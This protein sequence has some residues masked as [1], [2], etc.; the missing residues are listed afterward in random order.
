MKMKAIVAAVL[1]STATVAMANG[2][3][4]PTAPNVPQTP[5]GWLNRM[6]DFTKNQSAFKDPKVFVPWANAVTEPAFYT[7]MGNMMMDPNGWTHMFGTM[8][9]PNAYRNYA[10]WADPNVY[11]KWMAASMDPNF[12]TALLSQMTDPGKMMR[13]AMMPMDPK[14][15]SM[16]MQGMNPAMYMKWMMAPISPQTMQLGMAPLNPNL[17]MNWMGT[18]MNPS[19]YGSWGNWL[20]PMA[21]GG[22]AAPTFAWPVP[23]TQAA[24][25]PAGTVNFFD[26]NAWAKMWTFPTAQPAPAA[27]PAEPAA[28]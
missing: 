15:W 6:S 27:A 21:N 16:M 17:Y 22:T 2:T 24:G 5:E 7:T 11:M 26:P 25:A 4:A 20:Q 1:F 18:A 3:V 12:Y 8:M 23:T 10:E 14:L 19:T 13:W 9:D 28:K